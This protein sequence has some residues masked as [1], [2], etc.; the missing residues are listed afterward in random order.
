MTNSGKTQQLSYYS[1]VGS[2]LSHS[3][4]INDD[5]MDSFKGFHSKSDIKAALPGIF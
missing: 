3:M 2:R 1:H 5:L 4:P